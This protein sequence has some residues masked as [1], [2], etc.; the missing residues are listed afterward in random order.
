MTMRMNRP[1]FALLTVALIFLG[2]TAIA[3]IS[4]DNCTI[5]DTICASDDMS[6]FINQCKSMQRN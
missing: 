1:A 4:G 6:E 5:A 2:R 3:Q